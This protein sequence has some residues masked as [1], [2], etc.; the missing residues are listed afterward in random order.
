MSVEIMWL[1]CRQED[2]VQMFLSVKKEAKLS[3]SEIPELEKGKG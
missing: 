2:E 3:T 1:G